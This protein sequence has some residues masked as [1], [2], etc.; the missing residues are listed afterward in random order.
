MTFSAII[1]SCFTYASTL[2]VTIFIAAFAI[3]RISCSLAALLSL[4]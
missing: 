4:R 2:S 3:S 1:V